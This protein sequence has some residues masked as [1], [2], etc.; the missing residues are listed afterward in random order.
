MSNKSIFFISIF[1]VLVSVIA[2]IISIIA[3][4]SSCKL[5][6]DSGNA[7]M[8]TF[9]IMVTIL[10]G[11]V[12]VLIAWQVYNHYVAKDEVKHMVEEETKKLADDIWH[13]LDSNENSANDTC[14]LATSDIRDNMQL[15]AYMRGIT[16]AKDCQ[17]PSLRSYSINY[18]L[19][20]FHQLYI[21]SKE[22]GEM[23]I[24]KGKKKEYEHLCA[25][26]DHKYIEEL[27]EY[28]TKAIEV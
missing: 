27:K 3:F 22:K 24:T 10:I 20:R 12:T 4:W 23:H 26:I 21:E 9:S 6:Y 25:D 2:I 17:L 13:V 19:E 11:A 5:E 18:A 28:I 16:I 1:A 15:D 8:S 7:I 14:Y